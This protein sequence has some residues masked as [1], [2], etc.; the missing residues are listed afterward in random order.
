MLALFVDLLVYLDKFMPMGACM[1]CCA[2]GG[3]CSATAGPYSSVLYFFPVLLVFLSKLWDYIR[4]ASKT[5]AG[6]VQTKSLVT[7]CFDDCCV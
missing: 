5:A 3:V 7:E 1:T 2:P 6:R 4:P